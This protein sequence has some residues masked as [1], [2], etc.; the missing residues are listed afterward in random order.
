M[1]RR[2]WCIGLS[3]T[4]CPGW[5][6]LVP[7][8]TLAAAVQFRPLYPL[9]VVVFPGERILLRAFEPRYRQLI[10]ESAD[11]G[12]N[13]GIVTVV[14]GGISNV[15]TEMKVDRM[16]RVDDSGNLD[17]EALGLR[18][19][20]LNRFQRDVDGKLYSGGFVSFHKNDSR[21]APEIQGAIVQLYNQM[22]YVSGSRKK[23]VPPYP[24]NLSFMIGHDVGLSRSQELQ[25]ISMPVEQ[26]RQTFLFQHL[27]QR[28]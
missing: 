17:V 26:D 7:R 23:V 2:S 11:E 6:Q 5:L 27:L 12:T 19:F 3:L 14:P 24:D 18:V 8:A 1:N 21:I 28:R 16:V 9:G 25:L 20:N 22:Q 13:F 10:T 4:M 15:G